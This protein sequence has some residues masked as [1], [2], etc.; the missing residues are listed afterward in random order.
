MFA[1]PVTDPVLIFA[2]AMVIFLIAPLIMAKFKVTGIIGLILAGLIIG[3]NGLGLL[4]R[5]STILLLGAVGLHFIFFI[6]GLEIDLDGFKKYRNRSLTFGTLSFL[7]PFILGTVSTLLIG[8]SLLAAILIGSIIGSH[9]LL[10]YPIASR[11]GVSKNKAVTTTISG[12]II[13]DTTAFLILAVVAGASHG[14]LNAEFWVTMVISLLIFVL[15]VFLIVPRISKFFFRTLGSEGNS[16]FVFVMS[17]LFVTAYGATLAGIEAIIGAFLAGLAL[18]RFI[19]EQGTLMN[20]IKFVGNSIFIPFFLLSVGML[21]DLRVILTD[22]DT[23]IMAGIVVVFVILGKL[24]AAIITGKIYNY[25]KAEQILMFGLSVPQAAATLAATMVGYELGLLGEAVVN[26]MI[27]KILITCLIGPFLVEKYSKVLALLEEKRPY[28]SNQAPERVMIPVANPHT[29]QSLLD[30]AFIV[31]GNSKEPL[32][33]L[34]VA[35]SGENSSETLVKAEKVLN[36]AV[37]YGAGAEVPVQTLTRVDRNIATG[38]I[39]AMEESRITTAVIGWNGKLST[40]QRIF[41]SVLDQLLER[42]TQTILVTKIEY[43]INTMKRLVVV[44]PTGYTHKAGFY[45]AMDVIRTFATELGMSIH[46][47]IINDEIAHYKEAYATSN[48]SLNLTFEKLEEWDLFYERLDKLK[49]DDLVIAL[50]TRK[51]TLGWDPQLE[52]LPRNLSKTASESFIVLYSPE[53]KHVDSRGTKGIEAPKSVLNPK[54][55]HS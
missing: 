48:S 39:R 13:T 54:A 35:Q 43:P 16:E 31:R 33:A 37:S 24:L 51:G 7:I 25:S 53:E 5:D 49:K 36:E 40:P 14:V 18:N 11:L 34:S 22:P 15:A 46:C 29:L 20:R 55:Y 26:A 47:I 2:I 28:E 17:V 41:G 50:S 52:N 38:M 30:L 44:V 4:A 10:A 45:A 19:V 23:W 3:P 6:A 12:T 21:V 8:Y 27:I 32:Y 9:T 1:Q 42:S